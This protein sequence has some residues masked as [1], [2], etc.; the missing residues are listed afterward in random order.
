M[1]E[2]SVPA[3]TVRFGTFALDLRAGELRKNGHTIRLPEQPFQ[4]L[5]LLLERA[6]E[7]VTRDE[8]RQGLWPADTFVD[9]DHGLN[10]AIKKLRDVLDDSAES[11]RYIETLPKRGYRFI[12]PVNG[13][14]AS[15]VA[16][17]LPPMSW[18]LKRWV[19]GLLAAA[20]LLGALLMANIGGLRERLFG[21][22]SRLPLA[23]LAVL[24]L[25]NLTG[26]AGQEYLVDGIHDELITQ[27]AQISSLKVI[28]RY[29]VV[30]IKQEKGKSLQE[31]ARELGVDAVMEGTV[32]RT[33]DRIHLSVQVI[34]AQ[35]DRHLWARSYD[36]ELRDV[37]RLPSD[38]ARAMAG[39]LAI[40]VAAQEQAQLTLQ[41]TV[42]P[43][44]Y[45]LYLKANYYL[46]QWKKDSLDKALEYYHQ[47]IDLDPTYARAWSG[48]GSC[49]QSLSG[50]G[51]TKAAVAKAKAALLKALE[52]DDT[53]RTAHGNLAWIYMDAWDWKNA[54][55]E[56]VRAAELDPSWRGPSLYFSRLGLFDEAI[57]AERDAVERN[58]L[59]FSQNLTLGWTYFMAR[60][61]DDAIPQLKRALQLDP[62]NRMPHY[63]LA[64]N[65]AKKGMFKEAIAECDAYSQPDPEVAAGDDCGW[66]YALAGRRTEAL[67]FME[68]VQRKPK[69]GPGHIGQFARIYDALG[70]REMAIKLL[71]EK[72]DKQLPFRG[73]N[74][75]PIYSDALRADPRFQELVRRSGFP[76]PSPILVARA[77]SST[78]K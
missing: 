56:F 30:R 54:E 33:G 78:G 1:E 41:R 75:G 48:L 20:L 4:V 57:Q 73:I 77:H 27:L 32:Q 63:Q 21:T 71:Y 24:P 11:P 64:W 70:D 35:D 29:S 76:E 50:Y 13:A 44:V 66:V 23:S 67:A 69:G 72:Y 34:R 51:D 65:Y 36:R 46:H 15:A 26:D 9:F 28:S 58:P 40:K 61:Y 55:K 7:V 10:N 38:V 39:D 60:R 45:K 16:Q 49:Y 3:R 14:E 68:R 53:L 52:L 17:T 42:D 19:L 43:E 22:S 6:G 37:A 25:E 74:L 62:N 31:I 2:P 47:A 5:S 18:G 12:C 8:L 59:S